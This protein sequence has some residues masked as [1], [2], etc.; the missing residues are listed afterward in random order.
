MTSSYPSDKNTVN[1]HPPIA[2]YIITAILGGTLALAAIRLF[3]TKF[4]PQDIYQNPEKIASTD[5]NNKFQVMQ[6]SP[7][8]HNFVVTAINKVAPA[9]VKIN[10]DRILK[11]PIPPIFN[12]PSFEGF[13]GNEKSVEIPQFHYSGEGSGIVISRDGVILTNAHIVNGAENIKVTLKDGRK[14]SGTLLGIDQESDLATVKIT[15]NNLT[16][17]SL[18]QSQDL[19][20]GDWVISIGNPV[21]S[22]QMV[23]LGIV[24]SL[25]YSDAAKSSKNLAW[26]ETD[27]V[28]NQANSGGALINQK[29]Q[30]IGINTAM[31]PNPKTIGLV[32]PI[33]KFIAVKDKLAGGED[34]SQS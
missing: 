27:A 5:T 19:Q 26:I 1:L 32:I 9:V 22:E 14:F 23:S 21:G 12:D 24:S 28:I 31:K 25:K 20:L 3:P 4:I 2:A 33:E 15:A 29:G 8:E 11:I 34:I 6:L 13:F 10:S 30:V 7:G 17:A 18:G 16:T